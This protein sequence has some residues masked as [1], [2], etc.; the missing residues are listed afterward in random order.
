MNN[1]DEIKKDIEL[2]K[3]IP[4]EIREEIKETFGDILEFLGK[5]NFLRWIRMQDISKV[6]KQTIFKVCT[7][8]EDKYL[9]E[10][11]NIAGYHRSPKDTESGKRE[12]VFRRNVP[13]G[14]GIKSHE[15]FHAFA[16]GYGGFN[17]FWGEGITE[18]LSQ[19]LYGYP[20]GA[21]PANVRVVDMMIEMY[22][23]GIIRDYLKG[24]GDTYFERLGEQ[25]NVTNSI[26][27]DKD[28]DYEIKSDLDIVNDN[29]SIFHSAVYDDNS[30]FSL[31]T[32]EDAYRLGVEN[33]LIAFV[34]YERNKIDRLEYYTDG[35]LDFDKYR[36]RMSN[37]AKVAYMAGVNPRSIGMAYE[38]VTQSLIEN[39]HFAVATDAATRD[40]IV[41]YVFNEVYCSVEELLDEAPM[42]KINQEKEPLKTFNNNIPDKLIAL[43]METSEY[44]TEDY[45]FDYIKYFEMINALK[46][47]AGIDE[48]KIADFIE[49]TG[50]MLSGYATEFSEYANKIVN[51][52]ENV[53]ALENNRKRNEND[54]EIARVNFGDETKITFLEKKDNEFVLLSLDKKS[55]KI[56]ESTIPETEIS[57]LGDNL[58]FQKGF[59]SLKKAV[60]IDVMFESIKDRIK[61]GEYVR[62]EETGIIISYDEYVNDYIFASSMFSQG[63]LAV[64]NY[65]NEM[66]A[67]LVD[68]AYGA[69]DKTDEKYMRAK[70]E[71]VDAVSR[72]A[73][74]RANNYSNEIDKTW[75]EKYLQKIEENEK[76]LRAGISLSKSESEKVIKD[77]IDASKEKVA[78]SDFGI[79]VHNIEKTEKEEK[80][81]DLTQK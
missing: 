61:N 68:N 44:Y 50:G 58:R 32:G 30:T 6:A 16:D 66:T 15:I 1:I 47:K 43:K 80:Q 48:S 3:E 46:K 10:H 81:E 40:A 19:C 65:M 9:K 34:K 63:D 59:D 41:N 5:A 27:R 28:H 12:I 79:L 72:V 53:I 14:R 74:T 69:Q 31:E 38:L 78:S 76:V 54:S 29:F 36:E 22:G 18:Y 35:L 70:L 37:V 56:S 64:R 17:K 73:N 42:E 24:Q 2:N 20:D 7:D 26:T 45:E 13:K 23:P 77:V 55:G 8:E 67:M 33:L 71:I 25:V 57:D 62:R 49:Y 39:S 60:V 51:L 21:Y 52:Y 4:E 11:R 75:E